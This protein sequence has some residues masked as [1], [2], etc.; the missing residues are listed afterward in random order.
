MVA[1]Y[2]LAAP[3]IHQF[4]YDP[5][6]CGVLWAAINE[7]AQ[8]NDLAIRLKMQPRRTIA[9]PAKAFQGKAQL[10]S[11]TVDVGNYVSG[12]Q[13]AAL[14]IGRSKPGTGGS[15]TFLTLERSSTHFGL[16]WTRTSISSRSIQWIATSG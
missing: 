16:S 1:H 8:E 11:L 9:P 6:D 10:L 12:T 4:A 2:G 3:R 13:G 7:V 15:G 5:D 14:L